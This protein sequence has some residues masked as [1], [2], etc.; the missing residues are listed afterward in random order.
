LNIAPDHDSLSILQP[1]IQKND[2]PSGSEGLR[3][4]SLPQAPPPKRYAPKTHY[5]IV[6]KEK[7][8]T[9]DRIKSLPEVMT[10]LAETV[11]ALRLLRKLGWVHRDVSIRNILSCDGHAKL[12]DLEYAKKIGDS[13]TDEMRTGTM[14]FMSIEVAAHQFLFRPSGLRSSKLD[15]F[16]DDKRKGRTKVS[17]F[18]N[19]LHD[20]ES[21]WWVAVWVVLYNY[22]TPSGDRPS[23]ELR[24]A[25]DQLKLARILFPSVF[26]ITRQNG[27]Q[28]S[29]S[30]QDICDR[31]PQNKKAIFDFLDFLREL[32][33]TD[34][35]M[36]E[37]TQSVDP[38]SSSDEI[39]DHFT[40]VFS[41]SKTDS[42]GLVLY[43]IPEVYKTLLR[44]DLKR[45]RDES[46]NDTGNAQKSQRK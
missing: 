38:N 1:V 42:H 8:T 29:A 7:G 17:F 39:Y 26:G 21:L 12:A 41:S 28:N 16:V 33:I 4:M 2:P 6:F 31:L 34:Y 37:A 18:H 46:T 13:E 43:F 44:A 22:F 10:V 3:A 32:L 25:D 36:I 45:R 27:F 19:H 30:Y 5:R 9:I 40:Q 24:D 11:D 20:L 35:E 15:K 14:Q 23:F